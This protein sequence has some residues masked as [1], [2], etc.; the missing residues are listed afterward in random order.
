MLAACQV[1]IIAA[2]TE[3]AA[4]FAASF[5]AGEMRRLTAITSIAT[6]LGALEVTPAALQYSKAQPTMAQVHAR[7]RL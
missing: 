3:G 4:S 6:S 7:L 5:Q 1:T 2:E